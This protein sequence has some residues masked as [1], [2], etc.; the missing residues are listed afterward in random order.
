MISCI[1]SIVLL[2]ALPAIA[3]AADTRLAD[4]AMYCDARAY[5][6]SKF[7][8]L[9]DRLQATPDG[10]GTLLD[11]SMILYGSALADGNEHNHDPLPVLLAGGA[12]GQ[13]E[14]GRHIQAAAHTTMSNLLLSMLDKV[15][16]E[17][18]SFGDSTGK[19]EI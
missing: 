13:L 19:L 6:V 18:P 11:H 4:A 7:A 16:I 14:G 5:H 1:A 3:G 10:D 2:L 8:Y 12:S 9:L 15:G 17:M